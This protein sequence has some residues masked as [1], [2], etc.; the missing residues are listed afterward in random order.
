MTEKITPQTFN[1]AA[2]NMGITIRW[3]DSNQNGTVESSEVTCYGNASDFYNDETADK[4]IAA[5][6]KGATEKHLKVTRTPNYIDGLDKKVAA[7][8]FDR[9]RPREELRQALRDRD[10]AF[11]SWASH[12]I[13]FS[14]LPE[15]EQKAAWILIYE[16]LPAVEAVNALQSDPNNLKYFGR[17]AASGN[18]E[19][20]AHAWYS[21]GPWCQ[22]IQNELCLSDSLFTAQKT[23]NAGLWPTSFGKEE[24]TKIEQDPDKKGTKDLLSDFVYRTFDEKGETLK[25]KS[26]NAY[27]PLKPY[28]AAISAGLRKA[29]SISG[30]DTSLRK[31][32]LKRAAEFENKD[33]AY[34][35]F[36]G[37][38][39]W[40]A[41]KSGL[42]VTLGFYESYKSP[43]EHN[44]M[45]E[46]FVGPVDQRKEALGKSFQ[47]LVSDMEKGVATS[48]GKEYEAR[49]FSKGLPP[50]KFANLISSGDGRIKYVAAAYYLPNVAPHGDDSISKKV[51]ASNN[52][53]A[54]FSG[55]MRP[56]GDVAI[57]PSQHYVDE[58][59]MAVFAIAHENAHGVAPD[60]STTKGLGEF[61]SALEEAKADLEG[62]A[63]LPLAVKKE[64][65][66]QE[67]ADKAC[68]TMLYSYLRGL[69]YGIDDAHGTGNIIEFTALFKEGGIVEKDSYYMIN[70]KDGAI[71][72]VATKI[73]R[74]MEA[75]QLKSKTKPEEAKAEVAT[76]LETSKKEMP[77]KMKTY[78]GKL[79]KMPKDVLPWYH[80][81]FSEG[82][83]KQMLALRQS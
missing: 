46:A 83:T 55:V 60:R 12:T 45:M 56:M 43:F 33:S 51:F 53:L 48:L 22:E 35:F 9:T 8:K 24:V 63:S 34:P 16:V 52:I 77:A 73:A 78:V 41:V 6:K 71:Y 29:A 58:N 69:A 19:D 10:L 11:R 76:W 31:F 68:V 18:F 26:I 39:A 23:P 72:T 5:V 4:I 74:R 80:F 65:I 59:D 44:A 64:I 62:I 27:P 61:S 81:K 50:L 3:N 42:D 38:V 2:W 17:I 37:D 21:G 13:D 30:I 47:G 25:W 20:I 67:Q 28:L 14:N 40:V 54:R 32:F 36:D 1:D 57:H 66:T 75:I 15:A 79:E 49:D 70:F 7:L 82:V